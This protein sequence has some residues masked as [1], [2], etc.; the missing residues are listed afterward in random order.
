MIRR[1]S[2]IRKIADFICGRRKKPRTIL[3]IDWENLFHNLVQTQEEVSVRS[4][5]QNFSNLIRYISRQIGEVIA[6]IVFSPPYLLS[7]WGEV[8]WKEHQFLP[9]SCPKVTDKKRKEKDTVDDILMDFGRKCLAEV[10]FSHLCVATGDKD[11]SPLY[12]EAIRKGLQTITIAASK[13]S[14]SSDLIKRSDKII[15][16]PVNEK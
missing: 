3:L 7:Q 12:E 6:V 13:N 10:S 9:V 5:S 4:V 11:F 1:S 16:F 2:F 14:L 15:L 8:F